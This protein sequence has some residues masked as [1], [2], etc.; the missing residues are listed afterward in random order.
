VTIAGKVQEIVE[1]I[2]QAA[3]R[4]GRDPSTVQLVAATKT[5]ASS[6]L[7][8]AYAAGVRIFGENRLQEAQEKILAVGPRQGLTWHFIGQIQRRKLKDIVGNFTVLHSIESV[9]QARN[10]DAIAGKTGIQQ[11]ILLEVN[12]AGE[13]TKG[14][15]ASKDMPEAL[16]S[17]AQLSHVKI[18]GLMTL[19]PFGDNPENARPYF[20]E[21]RQLRDSLAG[22]S[23]NYGEL[24]ELSMGMSRDYQVAIEEGATMVRIG[25]AIFGTRDFKK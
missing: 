23:L 24:K 17:M 1:G 10:I 25:T 16:E 22:Q 13:A 20:T 19:P 3:R 15:F 21:L 5:M 9:E 6:Q 14:G 12:V 7:L 8:E 2:R 18:R 4:V 11:D